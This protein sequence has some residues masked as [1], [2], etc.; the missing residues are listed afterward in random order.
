MYKDVYKDLYLREDP[1]EGVQEVYPLVP[2]PRGQVCFRKCTV[3]LL[4]HTRMQK[5]ER[6]EVNSYHSRFSC[7]SGSSCVP[8]SAAPPE[9]LL[10][11]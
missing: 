2:V 11:K 1:L 4:K 3:Y 9:R 6:V 8:W 5:V 7:P 10:C